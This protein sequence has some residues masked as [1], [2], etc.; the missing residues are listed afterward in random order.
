M[1][2]SALRALETSRK[3]FW[4]ALSVEILDNVVSVRLTRI[5]PSGLA[6]IHHHVLAA[7]VLTWRM[8]SDSIKQ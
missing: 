7:Q 1:K 5:S 6:K 3:R 2:T 8:H 4:A